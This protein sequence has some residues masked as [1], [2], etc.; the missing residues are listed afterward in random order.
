MEIGISTE[1]LIEIGLN[2]AGFITAGLLVFVINSLI[3][4]SKKKT[5]VVRAENLAMDMKSNGMIPKKAE[6][7]REKAIKENS[8]IEFINLN[9]IDWNG[10]RKNQNNR[11]RFEPQGGRRGEIINLANEMMKNKEVNGQKTKTS[12]INVHGLPS[13]L[14]SNNVQMAG[15]S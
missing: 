11:P 9:G 3:T 7:S 12:S 13:F 2:V 1:Q 14:K 6:P 5:V 4:G 10:K 8:N 15:R